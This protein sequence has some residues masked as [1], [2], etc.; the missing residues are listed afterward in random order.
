MRERRNE[1]EKEIIGI[2]WTRDEA[3]HAKENV[4]KLKKKL[5]RKDKKLKK[6]TS[7]NLKE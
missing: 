1:K 7:F 4:K 6:E 5:R 2:L 3:K